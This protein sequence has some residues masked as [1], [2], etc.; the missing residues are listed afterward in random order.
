MFHGV[1]GSELLQAAIGLK[2]S[3]TSPRRRPGKNSAHLALVARRIDELKEGISQG[4]PREA[5]LRALLYIRSPEG[6]FDERGFNFLRQL[7]DE[8]GKGLTLREFKQVLR[9]QFFMLLLDERSALEAIPDL[10]ARDPDLAKRMHASLHRL[11]DVVGVRSGEAKSRLAEIEDLFEES[12]EPETTII[13]TPE[14]PH[15]ARVRH[16][17]SHAVRSPKH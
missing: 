5:V 16:I 3:D 15:L 10:L 14:K 7:R 11:L 17:R 12:A 4:G 8:A 1:Y 9:E 6:V 13:S 2:A